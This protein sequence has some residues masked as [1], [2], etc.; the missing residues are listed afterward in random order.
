MKP[1]EIAY[2]GTKN[3]IKR[4]LGTGPEAQDRS[5]SHISSSRKAVSFFRGKKTFTIML[6]H[7]SPTTNQKIHIR[8]EQ[9]QFQ[10]PL[11]CK[12]ISLEPL[13]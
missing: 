4:K 11:N 5:K 1:K 7:R 2:S 6:K 3:A 10:N 12:H 8:S 13:Q 9:H